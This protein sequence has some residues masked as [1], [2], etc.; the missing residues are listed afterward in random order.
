[1]N[2]S[3]GLMVKNPPCNSGDVSFIPGRRNSQG[4]GLPNDHIW[5]WE[6]DHKEVRT[7]KNW[8][9]WTVVLEKTPETPLDSKDI[10]PINF[11]GNDPWILIGGTDAEAESPVFWS[12]DV[13]RWFIGNVPDAMKDWEQKKKGASEDEMDG[14]HHWCHGYEFK[15]T[16]EDGKGQQGLGCCSPWGQK[17]SDMTGNWTTTREN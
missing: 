1:M 13:N 10:K 11:K 3:G 9:F 15:Q 12:A 5:L 16:L 7:S 14:W 8:C 6:L 17:D 2:S 4:Y